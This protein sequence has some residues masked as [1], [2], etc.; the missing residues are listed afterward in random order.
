MQPKYV[1]PSLE[2]RA[3]TCPRC[4]TLCTQAKTEFIIR[5]ARGHLAEVNWPKLTTCTNC[6]HKLIWNEGTLIFPVVSTAPSPHADLP[7]DLAKDYEEARSIVAVSPRGACALLR[8]IIDALTITLGGKKADSINDRIA[9]LIKEK[10]LAPQAQQA[11]DAVRVIGAN[12]VHPLEM[13]L[14]DDVA[15]ATK[16]FTLINGIVED[17]ITR[18]A[19]IAAIYG[20]L[21]PRNL[22]AIEKRDQKKD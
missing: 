3:F 19:A 21:P 4:H 9:Y 12:A 5:D 7:P 22:A 13:D 1:A 17:T 2:E 14:K 6:F 8:Y 16:L 18:P 15:L 10:G 20:A 11:L